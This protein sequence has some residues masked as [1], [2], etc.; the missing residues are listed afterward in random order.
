MYFSIKFGNKLNLFTIRKIN[1]RSYIHIRDENE[2]EEKIKLIKKIDQDDKLYQKIIKEKIV[3]DDE[4]YSKEEKKYKE[5][6]Y[7]IFDQEKEKAK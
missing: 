1:N 6:V 5:Y 3:I 4:K 2:F 7:H